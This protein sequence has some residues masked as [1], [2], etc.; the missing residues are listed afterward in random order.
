M[1]FLSLC[2]LMLIVSMACAQEDD[3]VL[4]VI[5]KKPL[6]FP[7]AMKALPSFASDGSD[8]IAWFASIAAFL[9]NNSTNFLNFTA[10]V[11]A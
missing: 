7:E 2:S 4:T 6:V 5:E 10:P 11:S 1:R 8:Q 9:G 3:E